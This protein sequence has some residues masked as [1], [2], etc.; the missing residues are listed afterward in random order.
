MELILFQVIGTKYLD[1]VCTSSRFLEF[2]ETDHQQNFKAAE[3]HRVRLRSVCRGWKCF[4]NRESSRVVYGRDNNPKTMETIRR[5]RRVQYNSSLYD[6]LVQSTQWETLCDP[7]IFEAGHLETLARHIHLH[8]RL[9]RLEIQVQRSTQSTL[10]L[11]LTVAL[12]SNITF[13]F[14]RIG[15]G[16]RPI[17]TFREGPITLPALQTLI[18]STYFNFADPFPVTI[19]NLPS[20]RHLSLKNDPACVQVPEI[21]KKYPKLVS[22]HIVAAINKYAPLRFPS[23]AHFPRLEELLLNK[24]FDPNTSTLLNPYHPLQRLYL[25]QSSMNDLVKLVPRILRDSPKHLRLISVDETW[26]PYL[27]SHDGLIH[28]GSWRALAAESEANNIQLHDRRG[29]NLSTVLKEM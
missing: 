29:L 25:R 19:L 12:L 16:D 22:F 24:P 26:L 6:C 4:L 28:L 1:P 20:L 10:C 7:A 9:R 23:L 3:R 11:Q 14:V 17:F 5:A 8:P 27:H 21:G 15:L 18:W 13:L 2:L